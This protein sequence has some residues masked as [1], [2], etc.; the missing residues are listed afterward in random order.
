MDDLKI[1]QNDPNASAGIF[2]GME[3]IFAVDRTVSRL[4]EMQSEKYW[5]LR[6]PS[7]P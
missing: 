3:E 5:Q 2:T 7:G 1:S 6:E 4:M